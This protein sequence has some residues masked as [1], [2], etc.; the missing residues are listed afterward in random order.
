MAHTG[1]SRAHLICEQVD[2]AK[3][4]I[5]AALEALDLGWIRD[6]KDVFWKSEGRPLALADLR[7][8][9]GIIQRRL[10]NNRA[11]KNALVSS[12]CTRY[13][14]GG[15]TGEIWKDVSEK[16]SPLIP[17]YQT[18]DFKKGMLPGI[19]WVRAGLGRTCNNLGVALAKLNRP[20]AAGHAFEAAYGIMALIHGAGSPEVATV[21][22]NWAVVLEKR[23][24]LR[25]SIEGVLTSL[26]ARRRLY[27]DRSI[28]VSEAKNNLGI[29]LWK[30]GAGDTGLKAAEKELVDA[31][32]VKTQSHDENLP[33]ILIA[34]SST[35][36][37]LVRTSLGKYEE[38]VANFEK[39]IS[40][41]ADFSSFTH[42]FHTNLRLKASGH[43]KLLLGNESTEIGDVEQNLGHTKFEMAKYNDAD[44]HLREAL[45]IRQKTGNRQKI[46]ASED[47]LRANTN[48]MGSGCNLM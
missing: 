37:G 17:D 15:G 39:V 34:N 30:L 40:E 45:R 13:A 42:R 44:V 26:T 4:N 38:A 47:A 1:L 9:L 23:G 27:G 41:D 25:G 10:G 11:A 46:R 22:L 33:S 20:M 18:K 36:L 12:L 35:N 5:I 28:L 31:L 8:N 19:S 32:F 14:R 3:E 6:P 2:K 43:Y 21:L 16:L 7:E 24:A 29:N 48:L